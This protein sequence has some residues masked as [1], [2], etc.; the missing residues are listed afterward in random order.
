[1]AKI[2]S[3]KSGNGHQKHITVADVVKGTK[4]YISLSDFVQLNLGVDKGPSSHKRKKP[5]IH[6]T[7]KHKDD[8]SDTGSVYSQR[9]IPFSE[10]GSNAKKSPTHSEVCDYWK[11]INLLLD[12]F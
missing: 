11:L 1:M 3:N 7:G 2:L 4:N 10:T 8:V 12:I 6:L 5:V 9:S